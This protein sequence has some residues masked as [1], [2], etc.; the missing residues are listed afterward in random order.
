LVGDKDETL[1]HEEKEK[2]EPNDKNE[3][4]E[5]NDKDEIN[6][7]QENAGDLVGGK[8]GT[9]SEPNDKNERSPTDDESVK[10]LETQLPPNDD[11]DPWIV[12][13]TS[14][15]DVGVEDVLDA[16]DVDASNEDAGVVRDVEASKVE[17][18][19]KGVHDPSKVQVMNGGVPAAVDVASSK[20]EEG[21]NI[22]FS[23]NNNDTKKKTA[24]MRRKNDDK[25]KPSVVKG[26]RHAR[27]SSAPGKNCCFLP[28]AYARNILNV[29]VKLNF[30]STMETN[31]LNAAVCLLG[32][33]GVKINEG[34]VVKEFSHKKKPLW[35]M[36]PKTIRHA[37]NRILAKHKF[38]LTAPP[39]KW[40][41]VMAPRIDKAIFTL[42]FA[43][44]PKFGTILINQ[45]C[46]FD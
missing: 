18:V 21:I 44:K 38:I 46:I 36:Q 3:T 42:V 17:V 28:K 12:D 29:D 35:E 4:S 14:K 30:K 10:S 19:Q 26:K 7:L 39:N 24:K 23:N 25:E 27:V 16:S 45:V 2:I 32:L 5:P 43:C 22:V 20:V 11:E 40:E 41:Y 33:V 6:E 9:L 31:V 37:Y 1:C 13:T 15:V 34:D 8:E